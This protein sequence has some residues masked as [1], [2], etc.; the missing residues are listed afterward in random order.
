MTFL[1]WITNK[2]TYPSVASDYI[3]I[4]KRTFNFN[5]N[6]NQAVKQHGYT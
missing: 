2:K 6:W 5:F 1:V 4:I 3:D